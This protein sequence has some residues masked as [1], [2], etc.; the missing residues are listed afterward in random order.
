MQALGS[1]A[2][3][4]KYK[5]F[6]RKEKEEEDRII[7]KSIISARRHS[8]EALAGYMRS[9]EFEA[10]LNKLLDEKIQQSPSIE[11]VPNELKDKFDY[12]NI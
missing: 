2:T 8:E 1:E 7:L 5:D 3:K 4:T 11:G 6:K 9:A 10:Q 12:W